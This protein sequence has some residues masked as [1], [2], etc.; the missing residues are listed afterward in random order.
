MDC[1]VKPSLLA[2][3]LLHAHRDGDFLL[4]KVSLE[5][6][7]PYFFAAGHVNYARY[8][9]WYLRNVENLPTAA[10]NDLMKCAHVCRH[11]DGGTAVP[12]GHLS[13]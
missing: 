4:Q 7:I 8:M 11:S 6:M 9:T 10:N 1:L 5:A 13:M 12:A 3:R 2:L